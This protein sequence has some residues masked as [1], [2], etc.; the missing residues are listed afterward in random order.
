MQKIPNLLPEPVLTSKAAQALP[1][2][3]S[4]PEVQHVENIGLEPKGTATERTDSFTR[5][6]SFTDIETVALVVREVKAD[7]E[8]TPI[9]LDE[10]RP[11]EVLVEMKYSGICHTDIVLQQGLL[12]MVEFPAIFGHEGAGFVRS[13]GKGV[14]TDRF[15]I[16]DAVLLSFNKCGHCK[17]C[18]SGHPASCLTFAEVNHNAVRVSDRTTPARTKSGQSVRSQY[19]GQSSFSKMSVVNE[20]CVV[21][22]PFPDK[23]HLYAPIGCGFQTGAGTVLNV[24]KP[25]KEDALVI[26]GLGSVGLAALM[27]AKYLGAG[28]II[29]VDIVDEKLNMAKELGAT[30]I[31]NSIKHSDVVQVIKDITEG[32]ANYAIDCTGVLKVI[33]TMIECLAPQGTAALVGVPPAGKKIQIDPLAFLS[34]SK[35][36]IG[37]IEGDSNP[38]EFIPQLVEMHQAGHFPIERLCRTYP[39]AKL[40]EAMHDLHTGQVIKPVIDWGEV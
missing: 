21:K 7:F 10:V 3:G 19:F 36:L 24:F 17:P 38:V 25:T 2:K 34:E 1:R 9:I 27:A 16:G 37:V 8:L 12:P 11:D 5:L 30:D 6:D 35:K 40:N 14:R 13:I 33:E 4:E 28:R 32:G 29:A 26:F 39:V 22:C 31:V 20:K 15:Q 23:L 18:K